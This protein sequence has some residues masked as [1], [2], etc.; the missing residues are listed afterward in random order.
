LTDKVYRLTGQ[1][2]AN[3]NLTKALW[4]LGLEGIDTLGKE[5]LL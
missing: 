2:I 4:G 5:V 3:M 1:D